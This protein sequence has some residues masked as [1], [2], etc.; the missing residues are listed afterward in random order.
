MWLIL[1]PWIEIS[2][3]KTFLAQEE[4]LDAFYSIYLI[5]H[6]FKSHR[7]MRHNHESSVYSGWSMSSSAPGHLERVSQLGSQGAQVPWTRD[8]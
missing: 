4:T 6:I 8:I 3:K 5:L 2:T 1:S 7:G